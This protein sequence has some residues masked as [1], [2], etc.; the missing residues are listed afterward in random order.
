MSDACA[1]ALAM[2]TRCFSPPLSVANG[3]V[4]SAAVP[5]ARERVAR[6]LLIGG[7]FEL[8]RAEVR[9]A[10]HQHHVEHAEVEGRVR[11]LRHNRDAA[12]EIAPR[13]LVDRP[14]VE[15]HARRIA[16]G[17]TPAMMRSS[18]VLPEPFGPSRPTIV[19][20]STSSDTPSSTR[21]SS[22]AAVGERMSWLA[23]SDC[24]IRQQRARAV[25]RVLQHPPP[26][27]RSS[28]QQSRAL[29]PIAR[30]AQTAAGDVNS[31][32]LVTTCGI[33]RVRRTDRR[34]A[35]RTPSSSSRAAAGRA[36]SRRGTRRG[37]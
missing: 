23:A 21:R 12:R 37:P 24:S 7:A 16:G 32:L 31:G 8:E 27:P 9:V 17:S 30:R 19:P 15:Q 1:S 26:G 4:S 5:V 35:A 2:T 28:A 33:R 13:Q 18:V 3:R 14:S 6:D 34:R 29:A 36:T 25:T 11:F 10:A 22:A 20:R